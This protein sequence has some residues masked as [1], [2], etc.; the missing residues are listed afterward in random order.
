MGSPL[1]PEFANYF[2]ETFDN[3]P[4]KPNIWCRYVEESFVVCPHDEVTLDGF[5]KYPNDI[6]PNIQFTMKRELEG[7]IPFLDP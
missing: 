3:A 2:V 5:L 7:R 6:H 1:S 4:L